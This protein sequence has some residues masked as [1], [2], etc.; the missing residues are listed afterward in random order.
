MNYIA[1][2]PEFAMDLLQYLSKTVRML[3]AQVDHITF[4]TA[5][6]RIAQLILN[7]FHS[8]QRS[9]ETNELS[10]SH[11]EIAGLVGVSRVTVSKILSRFV[12]KGWIETQ[13]KKIII[14]DVNN[15]RHFAF[16]NENL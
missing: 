1:T 9:N 11:E 2:C 6:K 13:Y 3:S 12:K 5:D 8:Q 15:L 4:L 16:L 10:C 14:L 7:L